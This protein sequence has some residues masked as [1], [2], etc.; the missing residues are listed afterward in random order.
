MKERNVQANFIV[1]LTTR[2]P[3]FYEIDGINYRFVTE[4]VFEKMVE[5]GELLEY[6]RVY[7]NWYGVPRESVMQ[8]IEA[9]RDAIIKVDIQG[10]ATI[11]KNMPEACFVF[12]TPPDVSAL[13]GRLKKRN[14][15]SVSDLELRLKTAGTEFAQLHLF[16][17]KVLNCDGEVDAAVDDV[18]SI[19]RAEKLKVC[20]G[21]T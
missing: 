21:Q 11:K 9:G 16:D 12:V 19:I 17:Y 13:S 18:I 14:T 4:P 15:E 10:A 2:P 7:G 1:T 20:P 5:N 8:S 3:R 6:A